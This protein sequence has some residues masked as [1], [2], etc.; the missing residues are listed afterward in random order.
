MSTAPMSNLDLMAPPVVKTIQQRSLMVGL[1][2]GVIAAV[3]AWLQPDQFFRAYLL[4]LHGMAGRDSGLDGDSHAPPSDQG[5][6]GMVIRR[7]LGAAMRMRA[8]DG[9]VVHPAAVLEYAGSTSGRGRWMRS[10]TNIC[11]S[12]CRTSRKTLS[13]RSTGS[14][15]AP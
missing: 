5:A 14:S 9:A 15:S 1:V 3:G 12:T 4:G 10:R 7:I 13:T 8:A 2:F 11:A 6:W